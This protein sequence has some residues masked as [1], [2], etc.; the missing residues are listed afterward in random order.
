MREKVLPL[1]LAMLLGILPLS[2]SLAMPPAGS[3]AA[4]T[5]VH[6]AHDHQPAPQE[7]AGC[8]NCTTLQQCSG[9]SC[10]QCH[11]CATTLLHLPPHIPFAH[12][13][14]P[15]TTLADNPTAPRPFLPFRPPWA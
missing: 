13:T 9:G 8:D 6:M 5:T 1:L 4:T 12:L 10:T 7:G 15:S 11:G 3:D 14:P 2:Q